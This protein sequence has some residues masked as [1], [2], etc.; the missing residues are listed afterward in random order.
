MKRR[1]CSGF[2]RRLLAMPVVLAAAMSKGFSKPDFWSANLALPSFIATRPMATG[3][4]VVAKLK[5]AALSAALT[6]ALVFAFLCLWLPLWAKVDQL[7]MLRIGFWMVYG[8]SVYPQYAIAA[9]ILARVHVADV[10]ISGERFVRRAFRQPKIVS[11]VPPPCIV[12]RR[13]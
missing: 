4:L 12:W 2:C 9:L 11:L 10:E 7:S 6:W 1:L 5:A 8:H 3:E 13:S